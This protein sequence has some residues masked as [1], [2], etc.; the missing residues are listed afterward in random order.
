VI[1]ILIDLLQGMLLGNYTT[2]RETLWIMINV[3]ANIDTDKLNI[4]KKSEFPERLVK[5]MMIDNPEIIE[6]VTTIINLGHLV[7]LQS[8]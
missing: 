5:I 8:R 6:N 3:L 2:A 4:I 7:L 1:N